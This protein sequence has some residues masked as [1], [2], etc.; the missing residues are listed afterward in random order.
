MPY[1]KDQNEVPS[2]A[3]G[4]EAQSE[5]PIGQGIIAAAKERGLETPSI[6]DFEAVPGKGA[7][8]NAGGRAVKV[9][10]PGYLKENGI[11]FED[12]EVQK[13]AADGET[14]V[15]V[16]ED[17]KL[18]GLIALHDIIRDESKQAV[19][20][21][22]DMGIRQMMTTGDSEAVAKA[23]AGELGLD[24]YF[25]EVLPDNKAGR[26][27][28]LTDDGLRVAMAGDGVNDAPALAEAD[29]GIAI[30][31]GTDVA[32]EAA[33]IVLVNSDPR[34][35]TR[36]IRLTR[37]TYRK[38][39]QNL[40]WAAGYNITVIPLV[41]GVLAWAGSIM[42]P[43]VGAL[44]MSMSTIIV[45]INAKLLS[46][47][48]LTRRRPPE[49]P[50][51]ACSGTMMRAGIYNLSAWWPGANV[52]PDSGGWR[53]GTSA[54]HTTSRILGSGCDSALVYPAYI[55]RFSRSY[56]MRLPVW[57]ASAAMMVATAC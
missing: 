54:L 55:R 26:I 20:S 25:A 56:R 47:P 3:V 15:C 50:P 29:V 37:A 49:D 32:I 5:H 51:L 39:V 45:T 57:S 24:N 38:M 41:A 13:L 43:A 1:D 4:I 46:I 12:G 27:R 9:V 40:W 35:V 36:T 30:G 16:L 42:T 53:A 44:V 21:L 22:R 23:V 8:A 48:P 31:A 2:L 28:E 10:S 52:A 19:A 6:S 11:G 7:Q 14:V 34:D 18:L 17:G 33:D